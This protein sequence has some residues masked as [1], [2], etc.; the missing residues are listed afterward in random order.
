MILKILKYVLI[1]EKMEEK[2]NKQK[3][4]QQNRMEKR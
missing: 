3:K 1:E 4:Q 2:T